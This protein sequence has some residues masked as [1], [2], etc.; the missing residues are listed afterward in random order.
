MIDTPKP[1]PGRLGL[2]QRVLP[3][4]RAPFFDALSAACAGGLSVFAGQP[5]PVESIAITDKLNAARF[6]Q[7]RNVHIFNPQHPLYFCYQRGL[8]GWLAD[9]NPDALII[10]ANFRYLSSPA[11]MRWMKKRSRPVIGWGLGAPLSRGFP[12]GNEKQILAPFL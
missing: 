5:L 12:K 3:G 11:A 9:W 2:I 6:A 1:F 4:Y 10:E 7:A 8:S